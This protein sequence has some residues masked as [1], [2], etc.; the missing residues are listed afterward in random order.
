MISTKQKS[1]S[2]INAEKLKEIRKLAGM[3][4]TEFGARIV[5]SQAQISSWE[6]GLYKIPDWALKN[7]ERLFLT[8]VDK[9]P[10]AS[11]IMPWAEK[12]DDIDLSIRQSSLRAV[13]EDLIHYIPVLELLERQLYFLKTAHD[14]L[15]S[16]D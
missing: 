4:Q 7:I 1:V 14:A 11:H 3:N 16:K 13:F 10:V 8:V 2:G 5:A 12:I 9:G 15:E 6:K